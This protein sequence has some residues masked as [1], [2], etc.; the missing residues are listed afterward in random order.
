MRVGRIDVRRGFPLPPIAAA[1]GLAVAVA[2]GSV[3]VS[4]TQFA[5]HACL[6]GEGPVGWLGLRLA[7]LRGS[8][9]CPDGMLALGGSASRSALVVVS[10]AL[11]TLLVHL[12]A[13]V[14]GASLSALLARAAS[15]I[16]AVIGAA[17]RGL[18]GAPRAPGV[19]VRR[20][21][22][23]VRAGVLRRVGD[24]AHPDRGPPVLLAA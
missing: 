10:V 8:V 11:P 12:F 3:F 22:G 19:R 14:C 6:P 17:W 18:P 24:L 1:A 2:L 4:R 5:L 23:S 20:V 7:L 16:R 15:G 13:A 21:I 9:D